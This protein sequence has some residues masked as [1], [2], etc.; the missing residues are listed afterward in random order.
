MKILVIDN[1]N[2]INEHITSLSKKENWEFEIAATSEM[3]FQ[4]FENVQFN[5]ILLNLE[6]DDDNFISTIKKIRLVHSKSDLCVIVATD[7]NGE[8]RIDEILECGDIFILEKPLSALSLKI[9]I[10][11][12]LQSQQISKKYE[13]IGQQRFDIFEYSP[14]A[15][16]VVDI[17]GVILE[18]NKAAHEMFHVGTEQ[19]FSVL[20]GN[21]FCCNN[22]LSSDGVCGKMQVCSDCI[23]RSSF[24]QSIAFKQNITKREGKFTIFVDN[25]P[26][27]RMIVVSA[28]VLNT[29]DLF[30]SLL[31]IED[32][33]T[34]RLAEQIIIQKNKELESINI[35]LNA[36]TEEL[37]NM[38]VSLINTNNKLSESEELFHAIFDNAY[39][40]IL[41][42]DAETKK[43]LIGN[44]MICKML[45]YDKEEI[46]QL[47]VFDIHTKVDLSNVLDGFEKQ[48][49]KEIR[50][51]RN[52]PVKRKD[53]SIFFAD[54]NSAPITIGGR[55]YLVGI[56]RDITE[57]KLATETLKV[58]EE[59]YRNLVELI[60]DVIV[61]ADFHG[62]HLFQNNA[63]FTSL[64]YEVN[65]ETV[66]GL[67]NVHP[68]DIHKVKQL[69]TDILKSGKAVSDYRVKHKNGNWI[70]RAGVSKL[71]YDNA[72]KP[73]AI[74]AIL[75]DITEQKYA[76]SMIR[77][78]NEA[79]QELNA[80]K[81]KFLSIIA[82]DLK[83]PFNSL[84]GFSDLLVKNLEKYDKEK[85]RKY[86][87]LI[88]STSKST[89]ILLENLLTWARAQQGKIPFNPESDNLFLTIQECFMYVNNAAEMKGITINNNVNENLYIYADK[90]MFHTIVRNLLANAIKF[91][92][93]NGLINVAAKTTDAFVTVSI[94][95]TGVGISDNRKTTLFNIG[96]SKSTDGTAGE[97]GTGL[98]L[99][100][101]KE[102]VEKHGGS[103]WVESQLQVGSTFYFTIPYK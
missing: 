48:L 28:I 89:Y 13:Q 53:G 8:Q 35:E 6:S 47:S 34:Q 80:M 72:G 59:K 93:K 22:A 84:I 54:V 68:D 41:L 37:R 1:Q 92:P 76:E 97:R 21:I 33:T 74:L 70:H 42:G 44:D 58:S 23:I 4:L 31:T 32:V 50:V 9:K 88:N 7:V 67:E 77:Q 55:N 94:S 62:K 85:L 46:T 10:K 40:G 29:N 65:S 90:V 79:L 57:S 91:T 61:V 60:D 15:S 81:D 20:C 99:L 82:H 69:M 86:V 98:G 71:L 66:Y 56:F 26:Q 73:Y 16:I 63:Y 51:A 95:D 12:M 14:I 3:A 30:Y 43:F 45:G 24:R 83:N 17:E 18:M 27:E 100:L 5:I 64:G 52:L 25:I 38:T 101:C 49:T 2:I 103:I 19:N 96:E 75:R 102:F 78:Q 39:D 11:S 87:E 36:Q